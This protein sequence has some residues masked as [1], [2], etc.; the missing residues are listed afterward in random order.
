MLESDVANFELVVEC[1][2]ECWQHCED[3]VGHMM[4]YTSIIWLAA[5]ALFDLLKN[6]TRRRRKTA[7]NEAR[8]Q[9]DDKSLISCEDRIV[10]AL[11]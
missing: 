11:I 8:T 9:P 1:P 4:L 7:R 6:Y 2:A 10:K 3:R 5:F